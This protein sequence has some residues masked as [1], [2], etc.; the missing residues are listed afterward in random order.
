LESHVIFCQKGA[1]APRLGKTTL[2]F[3]IKAS[4]IRATSIL[5][6]TGKSFRPAC[7]WLAFT[8]GRYVQQ[9]N[10][11]VGTYLALDGAAFLYPLLA[12]QL[13]TFLGLSNKFLQTTAGCVPNFAGIWLKFNWIEKVTPCPCLYPGIF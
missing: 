2:F 12:F 5:V 8:E 11:E 10:L 6:C 7:T 4:R 13:L 3:K 9:T 1:A